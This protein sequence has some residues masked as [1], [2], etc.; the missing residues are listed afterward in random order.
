[1]AA[2]GNAEGLQ[3]GGSLYAVEEAQKVAE[4]FSAGLEFGV[5]I[6]VLSRQI[7]SLKTLMVPVFYPFLGLMISGQLRATYFFIFL[8]FLITQWFITFILVQ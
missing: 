8:F 7:L 5:G 2:A 1:M 3:G 6:S 4:V